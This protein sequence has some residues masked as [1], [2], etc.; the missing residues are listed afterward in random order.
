MFCTLLSCFIHTLLHSLSLS[1]D[2][3]NTFDI[4]NVDQWKSHNQNGIELGEIR[5]CS[6]EWNPFLISKNAPKVIKCNGAD[7]LWLS[8]QVHLQKVYKD[9]LSGLNDEFAIIV[10][11]GDECNVPSKTIHQA[12]TQIDCY[13]FQELNAIKGEKCVRKNIAIN[14][15]GSNQSCFIVYCVNHQLRFLEQIENNK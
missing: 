2:H 9:K 3:V 10:T 8:Y 5:F 12:K 1:R 15:F 4:W 14:T 7:I 6:Q 11:F 13:N